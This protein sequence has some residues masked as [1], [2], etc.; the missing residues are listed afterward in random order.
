MGDR[1][2]KF[3]AKKASFLQHQQAPPVQFEAYNNNAGA[4]PVLSMIQKIIDDSKSLEDESVKEESEAQKNYET[5]VADSNNAIKQLA[6][7]IAT[8][9]ETKSEKQA[10]K[11]ATEESLAGT[12]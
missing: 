10:E 6:D 7:E 5:F 8:N 11:V 12:V 9:T 1:L 4:S 3:Y 2:N